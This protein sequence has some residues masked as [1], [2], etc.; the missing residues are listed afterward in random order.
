VCTHVHT[1]NTL[2]G[3]IL[4]KCQTKRTVP[5]PSPEEEVE[6]VAQ[7]PLG[8]EIRPQTKI[9]AGATIL[10]LKK[11]YHESEGIP[12]DQQMISINGLIVK[13]EDDVL[14][15]VVRA[16]QGWEIRPFIKLPARN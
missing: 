2:M 3:A 12:I 15:H 14:A 10:D 8:K 11:I 7:T 1:H 4:Q 13:D 9:K 6:I 16:D 5:R